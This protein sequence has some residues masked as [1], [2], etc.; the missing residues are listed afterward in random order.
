[1]LR[2]RRACV[3][4]SIGSIDPTGAAGVSADLAIYSAMGARGVSAIAGITAQNSAHVA[5]VH[6][7]PASL[8]TKQLRVIWEQVHPDAVCIGV[9]PSAQAIVA[10]AQFL[11]HLRRRPPIVVDPVIAASSGATLLPSDAV[12]ML[13]KLFRLASIITPNADEAAALSSSRIGSSSDAARAAQEL[14][15]WGCAVLVTGGHLAGDEISD[16]LAIPKRPESKRSKAQEFTSSRLRG[17]VRGAGG[18]L[19]AAIAVE[20]GRG[21]TLER[22][23]VCARAMVRDAW[24]AARPLGAGKPQLLSARRRI[25]S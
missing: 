11:R 16:I 19:A 23:V 8:V 2:R 15:R 17:R 5:A 24:R 10:I 21:A 22:A 12:K 1:M 4:C 25:S 9:V 14:T 6:P 18:I 20:L 3:V 13:P 7:M